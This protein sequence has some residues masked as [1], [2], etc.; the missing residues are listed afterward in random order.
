MLASQ[1]FTTPDI[2]QAI[3]GLAGKPLGELKVAIINEAYAAADAGHDQKWLLRELSWIDD[4]VKGTVAFVNIRAY[5]LSEIRERLEFA[6]VIYIVGGKQIIL[7]KLFKETCF[8]G[9]LR[10]MAERKVILGTSA[11]GNVLGKQIDDPRYWQDQYGSSVEFL[12]APTL[13]LVDFNTLP[14]FGRADHPKRTA[15][16][17]EPLLRDNPFPLYAITDQQA[18]I[19][20]DGVVRFVGG[21]PVIFGR[22]T[23]L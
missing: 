6:D 22:Q 23:V 16:I 19:Y 7:P 1:G 9:V 5:D 11:G 4:Y 8:D 3:A 14:H 10:D 12:A 18:V 20:D 15:E 2:A 17:L 13:G 21:E